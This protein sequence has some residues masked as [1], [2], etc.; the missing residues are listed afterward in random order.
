PHIDLQFIGLDQ[1]IPDADLIIL[2]G[3][4]NVIDDLKALVASG[5][6]KAIAKHCR[7][8][9]KVIGLCGG[10]QMLGQNIYDPLGIEGTTN[11]INGLKL[12]DLTTTLEP[13]KQLRNVK[14]TLHLDNATVEGYEIHSGITVGN[15]LNTPVCQLDGKDE[16]A[17]SDDGLVLGSYV[18]G[19]FEHS[20]A[21]A[22]LLKWAG[23]AEFTPIDYHALREADIE[24]LADMIEQHMD[25]AFLTQLLNP[26]EHNI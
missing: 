14:G 3:S 15:S 26:V 12:L 1:E 9:G 19:I 10:Y 8:G 16:G 11:H 7:Y 21:C 20:E 17:I 25:T 22:A 13:V 4:K 23:F 6:Q 18:H 24:R 5:W 2:P